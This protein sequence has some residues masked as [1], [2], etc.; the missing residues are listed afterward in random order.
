MGDQGTGYPGSNLER[1]IDREALAYALEMLTE[2]EVS[3]VEIA[4]Y[5]S[6]KSPEVATSA[7]LD[8]ARRIAIALCSSAC[9][10]LV[11]RTD[12]TLEATTETRPLSQ[13]FERELARVDGRRC[14]LRGTARGRAY[15]FESGMDRRKAKGR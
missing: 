12:G 13:D 6:S 15:Y 2:D 5:I 3:L 11:V 1:G 14:F 7:A 10:E 4:S 9:A 8:S